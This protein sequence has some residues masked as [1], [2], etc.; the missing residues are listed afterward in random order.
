MKTGIV[1][2]DAMTHRPVYVG[3]HAPLKECAVIMKKNKVGSLLVKDKNKLLGIFTERDMVRKAIAMNKH[4]SEVY[5][6]DVMVEDVVT[7]SPDKDIFEAIHKMKD[8]D[9]RHLP[10][11]NYNGKFVGL[12]TLKDIL[13]IQPQLFESFVDIFNLKEA[14]RKPIPKL[15][16]KEGI[17]H[18]CGQYSDELEAI[19]M[20]VFCPNCSD[21]AE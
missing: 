7:I 1:V 8:H 2:C 9:I 11:L 6:K 19:G 13:R 14:S 5:A 12:L 15:A 16:S 21:N 17:C 10:V 4:P 3:P 18:G 20:D